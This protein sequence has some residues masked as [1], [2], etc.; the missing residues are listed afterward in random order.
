LLS[1][2]IDIH[3][4]AK[5]PEFEQ[6]SVTAVQQ[7]NGDNQD[8]FAFDFGPFDSDLDDFEK[9]MT[10]IVRETAGGGFM[11]LIEDTG[12]AHGAK[13]KALY[14]ALPDGGYRLPGGVNQEEQ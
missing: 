3:W 14:D 1:R 9:R 11:L 13:I 12:S 4:F 7:G 10:V 2:S 5:E 8:A 6:H